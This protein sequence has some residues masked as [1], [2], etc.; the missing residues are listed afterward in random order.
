MKVRIISSMVGLILLAIVLTFF[1]TVLLNIA[2]AVIS[3]VG[4]YEFL[5]ATKAIDNKLLSVL[6]FLPSVIIAF[7]QY[8]SF[9][10][11]AGFALIAYILVMFAVL[12]P[13]HEK[14]TTETMALTVLIS[15]ALPFCLSTIN[16]IK[17]EKGTI[18]GIYYIFLVL[19]GAWMSDTGAYFAGYFFGKHKLAPKISPKKTI[20]G[21]VGGVVTCTLSYILLG[22][23]F[24]FLAPKYSLNATANYL[25]LVIVAPIISLLS[26]VGDLSAS[27]IKRQHNIKDFGNIMP[28][29]GGV[30]D[31]F[32][33]V[34]YV[35]G[36]MYLVSQFVDFVTFI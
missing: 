29:H 11:Y 8:L 4:V 22:A 28:G 12:L 14:T 3:F 17:L 24:S 34:F 32:D 13:T 25:Q 7:P 33:S 9:K 31:R 30:L 1:D 20:E 27:L 23:I 26:I 21:A 2:L 36:A 19:C 6:A 35:A 16:E 18:Y 10:E 15:T 5:N